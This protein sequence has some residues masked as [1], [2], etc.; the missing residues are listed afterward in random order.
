MKKQKFTFIAVSALFLL[1]SF[2]GECAVARLLSPENGGE[3]SQRTVLQGEFARLEKA[4][5]ADENSFGRGDFDKIRAAMLLPE[6]APLYNKRGISRIRR[7][8]VR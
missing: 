7:I 3:V 4:L 8:G 1:G 2:S 6:T 5:A